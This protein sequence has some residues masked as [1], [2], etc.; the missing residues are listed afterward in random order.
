MVGD[1]VTFNA[2]QY[3][4]SDFHEVFVLSR[5]QLILFFFFHPEVLAYSGLRVK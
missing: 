1:A 4:W 2:Y 3:L 5:Q